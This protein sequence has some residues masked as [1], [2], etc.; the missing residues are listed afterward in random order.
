MDS[1]NRFRR[2]R[3]CGIAVFLALVLGGGYLVNWYCG[4]TR[5]RGD[6]EIQDTGFWSYPRYH[7]TFPE[8]RLDKP[9]QYTYTRDVAPNLLGSEAV[10]IDFQLDKSLPPSSADARELGV[11]VA[12]VGLDAK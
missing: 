7:I 4:A 2:I 12:S 6:G 9:G 1:K 8:V 10:R 3:V 11:I 5:F